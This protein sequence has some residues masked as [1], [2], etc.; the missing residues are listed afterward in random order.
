V[1]TGKK[2]KSFDSGFYADSE[3][4]DFIEGV[5]WVREGKY[6]IHPHPHPPFFSQD[7]TPNDHF[8][9]IFLKTHFCKDIL[10]CNPSMNSGMITI[11]IEPT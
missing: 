2:L 11:S 9:G 5:E 8:S 1:E 6:E 3:Y 10:D 4:H 7:Y